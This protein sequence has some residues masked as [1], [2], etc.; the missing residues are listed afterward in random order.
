MNRRSFIKKALLLGAVAI[1]PSTKIV[2][3]M[4]PEKKTPT[5]TLKHGRTT[6]RTGLPKPGWKKLNQGIKSPG[7][8]PDTTSMWGVNIYDGIIKP[9]DEDN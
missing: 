2:E 3:A 8:H 5:P 7:I 6:I 1:L 4:L 9:M